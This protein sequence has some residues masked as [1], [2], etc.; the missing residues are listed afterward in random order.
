[1]GLE[2]REYNLQE[3]RV[4]EI[5]G[6]K[7]NETAKWIALVSAA[8]ERRSEKGRKGGGKERGEER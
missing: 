7:Q 4:T 2:I 3:Y 8:N 1:M 5:N 6:I